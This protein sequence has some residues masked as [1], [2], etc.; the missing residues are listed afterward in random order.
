RSAA[1][2]SRPR[3][4]WVHLLAW[5]PVGNSLNCSRQAHLSRSRKTCKSAGLIQPTAHGKTTP[6]STLERPPIL[7]SDS[8]KTP[9]RFIQIMHKP[10][11]FDSP[12]PRSALDR[13]TETPLSVKV[14]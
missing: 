5:V 11:S 9:A 8:L 2:P 14:V 6:P 13:S 12:T 3:Q 1:F 10:V 7:S 4:V